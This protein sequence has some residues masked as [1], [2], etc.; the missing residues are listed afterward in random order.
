M[1]VCVQTVSTCQENAVLFD[2]YSMCAV[3]V[4][5]WYPFVSSVISKFSALVHTVLRTAAGLQT[6]RTS[7]LSQA[8]FAGVYSKLKH[9]LWCQEEITRMLADFPN[10]FLQCAN[11]AL[12]S[13]V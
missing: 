7:G 10:I 11:F 6:S 5:I 13:F 2:H 4:I 9:N 8:K 12:C 1:I 3:Y